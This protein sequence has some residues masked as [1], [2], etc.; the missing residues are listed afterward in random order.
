M[1]K[2]MREYKKENTALDMMKIKNRSCLDAGNRKDI[3]CVVEGPEDNFFVVDLRTAIDIG[4][5]YRIEY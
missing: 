3:Y 4:L 2:Y 1:E 5:G